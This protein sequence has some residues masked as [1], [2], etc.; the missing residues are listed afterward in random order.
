MGSR[1]G[2]YKTQSIPSDCYAKWNT[3]PEAALKD[4]FRL[5][6]TTENNHQRFLNE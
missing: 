4:N 3:E 5:T 1:I 2:Q 6:Q